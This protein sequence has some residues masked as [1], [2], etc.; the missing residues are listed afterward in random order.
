M[1]LK[2]QTDSEPREAPNPRNFKGNISEI[3]SQPKGPI[4]IAKKAT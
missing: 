1:L 2:S 4:L 3:I